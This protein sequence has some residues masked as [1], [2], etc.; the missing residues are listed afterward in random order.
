MEWQTTVFLSSGSD[1][2]RHDPQEY[3]DVGSACQF[4]SL[5]HSQ[6]PSYPSEVRINTHSLQLNPTVLTIIQVSDRTSNTSS[7]LDSLSLCP[8]QMTPPNFSRNMSNMSSYIGLGYV[9]NRHLT[10]VETSESCQTSEILPIERQDPKSPQAANALSLMKMKS[11]ISTE[12]GLS[13]QTSSSNSKN[14]RRCTQCQIRRKKVTICT[15]GFLGPHVNL[16]S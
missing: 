7:P 12:T 3:H 4:G 10:C 1:P 8:S 14:P 13:G 11:L 15:S 5:S 6:T 16:G 9:E 2:T